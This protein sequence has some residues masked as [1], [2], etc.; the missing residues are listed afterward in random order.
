MSLTMVTG[1]WDIGRKDVNVYLEHLGYLLETDINFF[2]YIEEKYKSFVED[3]RKSFPDK[4]FIKVYELSD[5]KR[6]FEPFWDRVQKIRN[7]EKWYNKSWWLP[8]SPQAKLE[9]YNPIVMSKMF[10]LHD[11]TI[12]NPFNTDYFM[13]I[14][15]G[16]C[17]TVYK[18]YFS[19][20]RVL[21]KIEPYLDPFLFLSYPYET[22]VEIH[23]FDIKGMDKYAGQHVNY[24]CR[25]GLFGGH[26]EAIHQANGLYYTLLDSSLSE[27]Y[28][29]TEESIFT[30][31]AYKEPEMYRRYELDGNGLIVKFIQELHNGKP[32]L[33]P[34]PE[35]RLQFRPVFHIKEYNTG[36]YFLTYNFPEQLEHVLNS[37]KKHSGFL[38]KSKIFV[39]DNSEN[40]K[41]IEENSK[42][43]SRYN[44]MHVINKE[45]RGINRGRVQAAEMFDDSDLDYYIFV[46]D[47]MCLW[48]PH[49]NGVCRCGFRLYVED[50]YELIHIIVEKENLDF[51]KMSFSEVFLDN[52]LQCAWYN[53][54][55]ELRE[56]LWPEYGTP[57]HGVYDKVPH[58]N[59]KKISKVRNLSYAIGEVYYANWP[60]LISKKGNKKMF[61]E[62]KFAYPYEQTLMSYIY[63]KTHEGYIN[64]GV[65][66]A[67]PVKHD[68]LYHYG[69]DKRKEV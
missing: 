13:W 38:E 68:R 34:I 2:I 9:F 15:A 45:N 54:P 33:V 47:D 69:S 27:G 25:G 52:Y 50:L 43:V 61:L 62:T 26:K 4:T 23:G 30:I 42:I 58:T 32:K 59:F 37:Y 21:D 11:V 20:D 53:V 66:L 29:G 57:V 51:L 39:I 1:F 18:N 22:D 12:W 31:M 48:E 6:M 10:F 24:V 67:S 19:Q 36:I 14:D 65:L 40:E 41:V 28:M 7:D 49:T 46:E 56:K 35:H 60:M 3:K 8:D 64:A 16:L 63:Q 55:K 17:Q 44:A 5:V